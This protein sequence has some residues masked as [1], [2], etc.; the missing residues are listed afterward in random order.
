[1]FITHEIHT[2][3]THYNCISPAYYNFPSILQQPV[4]WIDHLLTQDFVLNENQ[5]SAS[6]LGVGDIE[7]IVWFI[8][9]G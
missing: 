8:I 1:M 6:I 2:T 9:I 4:E 3:R 7:N 5:C